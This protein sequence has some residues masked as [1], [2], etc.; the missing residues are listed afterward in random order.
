MNVLIGD[1]CFIQ[2][3][4]KW[5]ALSPLFF[6]IVLEDAIRKVQEKHEGLELNGTH[7]LMLCADDVN[8]LGG[9]MNA[10]RRT[11]NF[12]ESSPSW[13][14]T[15]CAATEELPNILWNLKVHYRVLRS[16]PLIP[17]LS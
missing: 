8:L 17:I 4:Q 7:Q 3:A 14:P 15:S 6:K 9:N 5:D 2:N 10:I 12:M 13:E 16:P 11:D 1:I